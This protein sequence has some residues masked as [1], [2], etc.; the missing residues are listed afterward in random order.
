MIPF[1]KKKKEKK[2]SK[3]KKNNKKRRSIREEDSKTIMN[4]GRKHDLKWK[5]SRKLITMF[6]YLRDQM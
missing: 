2:K 4:K 1:R 5:M 3:E 6:G